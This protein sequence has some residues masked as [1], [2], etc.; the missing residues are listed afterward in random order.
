MT[1]RRTWPAA[2]SI[3][4]ADMIPR[5]LSELSEAG[6]HQAELSMPVREDAFGDFDFP[7]RFPELRKNARE[8]GVDISSVHLPYCPWDVSPE[9]PDAEIRE[10]TVTLQCGLI[11]AA[12]EAGVDKCI[13]HPS[14]DGCPDSERED[15]L[16]WS[17]ESVWK[18][19]GHAKRCGVTLCLENLPRKCLG[20][21]P[22][23][24]LM[25]LE[26]IP[27]LRMVMDLNHSLLQD[28]VSFIHEVGKWIVS[29]HVSDYDLI[30][31]KH[32]LP[33]YGKNDWNG[34][35]KALEEEDY[36]GR[37][38]YELRSDYGYTYKEIAANYRRYIFGEKINTDKKERR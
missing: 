12:A 18:I 10:K 30:D 35:L 36:G 23:E 1:D 2:L 38:L 19:N 27:G 22:G 32:M 3:H 31:E 28:N 29:L 37:F 7:R 20:R 9:D 6:I 26:N 33:G 16:K 25:Y 24:M 14:K 8:L 21:T 5:K 17:M 15:R 11:S 34:I 13:M 4:P